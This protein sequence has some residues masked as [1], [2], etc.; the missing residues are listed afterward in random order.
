MKLLLD[1][2]DR[3]GV[4]PAVAS[5]ISRLADRGQVLWNGDAKAQ[6][7]WESVPGMILQRTGLC[8]ALRQQAGEIIQDF[9]QAAL[10]VIV[11]KGYDF[12]DRLYPHPS[13]R[14]FTDVDLLIPQ[15]ALA[16]T[17]PRMEHLGYR[18]VVVAMKHPLGYGEE[19][20]HRPQRSA[21]HVEV[22]TNLV[23]SPTLRR[24][25]SVSFEDLQLTPA[26]PLPHPSPAGTILIAAVHGAAS[27][28]FDRLQPLVDLTLAVRQAAGGLD[29]AWLKDALARTGAAKAVAMGLWLAYKLLGESRCRELSQRLGL[30]RPPWLSRLALSRG[31][32]LRGHARRDSLRRQWFRSTLKSR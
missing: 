24:G 21:G 9:R 14:S 32:V 20:W 1:L 22:H 26:D 28:S 10:P 5:N 2:A 17:R 31:V 23:N 3:H 19:V 16:A 15:S 13:L 27:H 18:P 29:E 30:S 12:A 7:L 6:A 11:L 8:L 25:V 4:L